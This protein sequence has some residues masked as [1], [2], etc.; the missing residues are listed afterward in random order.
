MAAPVPFR[1]LPVDLD[2][3]RYE[4]G[5]DSR[6]RPDVPPGRTVELRLDDSAVYPGTTRRVWL[7]VPAGL[8]TD[9]DPATPAGSADPA[10]LL[11][12]QDGWWYLD[13]E[14][15]VRGGIVLDNLVHDG[16]IPPTIGVFVDPGVFP[17]LID[18]TARKNRNAE[19]DAAD[20]R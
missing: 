16:A 19:Y 6:R 17:D 18:P 10:G 5:P 12:F 3:V 7:H 1:P 11:V 9:A 13:P 4:L 14:G 20:D 15:D 2:D 8:D